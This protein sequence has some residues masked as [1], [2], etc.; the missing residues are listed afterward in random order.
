MDYLTFDPK[1]LFISLDK[2]NMQTSVRIYERYKDVVG[3]FKVNHASFNHLHTGS[4]SIMADYK[5]ID[6][7]ATITNVLTHLINL[8]VDSVT[9]YMN[10]SQSAFEACQPFADKIKLLGVTYLTSWDHNQA[11]W[12]HHTGIGYMFERTIDLMERFNFYGAICS[13][14]DLNYFKDSKLK[15][16]CPGVRFVDDIVGDQVRIATPEEA[17]D[18]GADYVIMGRPIISR[19]KQ[20]YGVMDLDDK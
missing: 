3:G 5:L 20:Q 7:P 10:N 15:R 2:T 16:L 8:K 19:Y 14:K 18:K 1:K 6:I 4:V 11:Q 12:I 9:I 17:F 13:P